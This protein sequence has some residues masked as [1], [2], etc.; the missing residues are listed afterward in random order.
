[1]VAWW[2]ILVSLAAGGAI[3]SFVEYK[4]KYNLTDSEI[5]VVKGLWSK[6]TGTEKEVLGK[7]SAVNKAI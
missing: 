1:M 4:L 6:L 5:D 2:W 3:T 7:I